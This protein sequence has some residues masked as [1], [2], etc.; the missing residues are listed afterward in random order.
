MSL[1]SVLDKIISTNGN[2]NYWI[3]LMKKDAYLH[4]NGQLPCQLWASNKVLQSLIEN[5]KMDLEALFE[6]WEDDESWEM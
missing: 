2:N 6:E 5:N 1:Q 3:L 4:A